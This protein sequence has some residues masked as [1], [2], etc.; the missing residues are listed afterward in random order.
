MSLI[1]QNG[2]ILKNLLVVLLSILLV[3]TS[4]TPALANDASNN[5]SALGSSIQILDNK[6][7]ALQATY[8]A[9]R[10]G[11]DTIT[12]LYS[13]DARDVAS[14]KI[15][16]LSQ[17]EGDFVLGIDGKNEIE[18][19][20]NLIALETYHCEYST[21][22]YAIRE[23]RNIDYNISSQ[24]TY[25]A[26]EIAT[27]EET[28]FYVVVFITGDAQQSSVDKSALEAA[29]AGAP[30][31]DA[32]T[33]YHHEN[34]RYNGNET[35]QKGFWEEY[36]TAYA[37]AEK[38]SKSG[39][40]TEESV[41]R[42]LSNLQNAISKLIPSSQANTTLLY[43]TLQSVQYLPET[44]ET[45][46]AVSWDKYVKAKGTAQTVFA[47][48][49]EEKE[50]KRV[51]TENN[52]AEKQGEIDN[53]ATV[54]TAA[55][56]DLLQ[57]KGLEERIALWKEASTWL[58]AQNQ[59]VQQGQYT[60]ASTGDWNTAYA[61]L[62]KAMQ[63][64][65]QTQSRYDAYTSSI[66]ALSAA[67][68]NLQDSNTSDITVHV[69]VADNFGAM[70]PEYAIQ[71]AKTATFDQNVTLGQGN[72]TISAMLSAMGY[73]DTPKKATPST[74][75]Q[76]GEGWK[77]P[78]VMVYINGTLAVNRSEFIDSWQGYIGKTEDGK[79]NT[80]KLYFDVQLHDGD[81]IV[82]LRALG[83]GYN[84]YGDIAA[85]VADYNFYYGSLALLN[86]KEN[87][88]E[89]EA[90]KTFTVNVEKTTAA[91][92]AKK[93]QPMPQTSVF[94][95]VKS[96]RQKMPQKQHRHW[97]QSAAKPISRV[98]RPRPFIKRAGI[99]WEPSM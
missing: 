35:S 15:T 63:D 44:N 31:L 51:A 56:E 70:F 39:A 86:I 52:K 46:T 4:I 60:E 38:E 8:L 9:E 75:T 6:N 26:I 58:L 13:V 77:N 7:Q 54:L 23:G 11:D 69:R 30:S 53:A 49:F 85:G 78:E 97:R 50:G 22:N 64:G 42:A 73:D 32:D 91:A 79:L 48:L 87:V 45:W 66:V 18:D 34:D 12:Y 71:D 83:P 57:S 47:G 88:I 76:Y 94:S 3:F 90:G 59:Q 89:V 25:S 43:E 72:K 96:R 37:N 16:G 65:Y 99:V 82:I 93:R 84:Y 5:Q 28:K 29:I 1:K 27:Q 80:S 81:E 62:K 2:F 55:K 36:K 24:Y 98:R 21:L 67:Y 92:E 68:Y 20:T 17:D 33:L 95:S 41:A 10:S 19:L 14:I 74:G 40:A 61:S